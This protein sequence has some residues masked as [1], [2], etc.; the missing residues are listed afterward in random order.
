MGLEKSLA[1][2]HS[3]GE[4][5]R[6]YCSAQPYLDYIGVSMR[7]RK[8]WN[9]ELECIGCGKKFS[10]DSLENRAIVTTE[11]ASYTPETWDIC[12]DCRKKGEEK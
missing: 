12:P 8:E 3:G 2:M 7:E 10:A 6:K 11:K 1:G 4:M 9:K 5:R